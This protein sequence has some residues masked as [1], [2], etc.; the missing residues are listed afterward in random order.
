MIGPV[1]IGF[2]ALLGRASWTCDL[3]HYNDSHVCDCGCSSRDPDCDNLAN[4]VRGCADGL[5]CA[6]D[7]RC[8]TQGADTVY[9]SG[10]CQSIIAPGT[11][12]TS[13]RAYSSATE[14]T[15][16]CPVCPNDL[17]FD[18]VRAVFPLFFH[19]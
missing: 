7:G 3:S 8:I 2:P 15:S 5:V 13:G 4:P 16:S 11:F 19:F 12:L 17:L 10:A 9:A 6:H 1:V 18:Q 14:A